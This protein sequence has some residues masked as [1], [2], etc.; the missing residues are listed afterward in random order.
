[1]NPDVIQVRPLDGYKVALA[2]DNGEMG[3]FDCASYLCYPAYRELRDSHYF[4][5]VKVGQGAICWPN[6]QDFC[7][8]TLYLDSKKEHAS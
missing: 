3:V 5:Q 6:G 7:P 4:Q 1:M 2:F 8:D